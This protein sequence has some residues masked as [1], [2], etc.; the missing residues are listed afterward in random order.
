[1]F[2]FFCNE[3]QST[4]RTFVCQRRLQ[5]T[6]RAVVT[7]QK[8]LRAVEARRLV[9][10]MRVRWNAAVLIQRHIRGYLGRKEAKQIRLA[11]N[12]RMIEMIRRWKEMEAAVIVQRFVFDTAKTI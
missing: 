3:L 5:A 11:G 8:H 7:I 9:K 6:I 10:K 12:L 2:S 1:M 4:W